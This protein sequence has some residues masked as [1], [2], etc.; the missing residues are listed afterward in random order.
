[1]L[2]N[3]EWDR[4]AYFTTRFFLVVP[5]TEKIPVSKVN[6]RN[7]HTP[8]SLDDSMYILPGSN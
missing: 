6:V 2:Y 7:V 3:V 1:M 4:I 8:T 5:G